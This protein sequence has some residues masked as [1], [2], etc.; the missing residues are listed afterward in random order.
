VTGFSGGGSG[1]GSVN[2][3]YGSL[4]NNGTI[5]AN[6]GEGGTHAVAGGYIGGAGGAGSVRYNSLRAA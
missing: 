1:G 4:L 2:I 3:L 5:Q 6:G